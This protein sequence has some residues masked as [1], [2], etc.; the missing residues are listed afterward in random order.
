MSALLAVETSG[1]LCS[2]AI[3]AEGRWLEDTQNVERLHNQVVLPQLEALTAAAGLSR[4]AFTAVAFAA[5]PGSF[6]GIRI[7][8]ALAQG[9]AFASGAAVIPVRSSR[10]LALAGSRDPAAPTGASRWLTVTRSRR[11]AYYLAGYRRLESG[12]LEQL[13]GDRLHQGERAPEDLPD[14]GWIGVGQRPPWWPDDRLLLESA[15]VTARVVGELALAALE[16]GDA[17]PPSAAIPVYV[18]GDSPWRPADQ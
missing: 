17:L 13:L 11:D 14:E 5:G 4:N 7:A 15:A 8:A 16:Q 2:L 10:A 12:A 1:S 18:A 3:H 6:T 9:V